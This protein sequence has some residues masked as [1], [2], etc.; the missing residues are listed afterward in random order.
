MILEAVGL[1]TAAAVVIQTAR[2]GVPVL[3]G[4]VGAP[5][6][7]DE[8]KWRVRW[9]IWRWIGEVQSPSTGWTSVGEFSTK[10]VAR[11]NA[12]MTAQY[13]QPSRRGKPMRM[14]RVR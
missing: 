9:A 1:A 14:M 5:G 7:D 8:V 4:S 2:R 12:T 6:T 3:T 10:E 13:Y 11:V